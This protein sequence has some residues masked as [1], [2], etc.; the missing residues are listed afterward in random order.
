MYQVTILGT[1]KIGSAIA[2]LL[3]YS[4]D[5][6]ILVGDIDP[7][8]LENLTASLPVNTFVI[9]VT[10]EVA[11]AEKLEGQDCVVSACSYEVNPIIARAA[12][13]AGV[14]YFDLTEDVA[15]T[16]AVRSIAEKTPDD[17]I[18][19]P[20]CGLAPGFIA[21]L[22][23][24]LCSGFEKLDEVKMRVGAL[25][26]YPSNMMMYNLTWST[27]GL[28][29]EYCN[30]CEAIHNGRKIEAMPLEE[31][32]HFSVDGV[33]YEAFNT[34]G[35]LGTLCETLEG[36]VRT[37]NYKTVR[38][39]GHQYL[40]KFLTQELGLS[41]RRELLQEILENSIPIT[42]QDVV[43][44][45]CTVTG[46][47]NGYLQQISDVRKIY[48]LNLH[49]ETWSSIQLTTSASVCAVLDMYLHGEI[50]HTGFLKQEQINLDA[51]LRNRF[52]CY[53]NL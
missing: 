49:G 35:G 37:L 30:P 21:I 51:F 14:S 32:E 15:T 5:Y 48:S 39:P 12:A 7:R 41:D 34:S 27:K 53:Y 50:P 43:V 38:Y 1:G 2:K 9:D 24:H 40:M 31:V 25:P 47:K 20:Q 16:N 33:N 17:L 19:A 44:I 18:F 13:K 36:Q 3:H 45:F 10:D 52:G 8:A 4:G 11:L 42:K 28:I 26:Q 22:A 46:W 29:N 6:S 23:H